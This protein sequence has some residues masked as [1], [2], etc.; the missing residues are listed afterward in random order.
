[1]N[2][3][4]VGRER[5]HALFDETPDGPVPDGLQAHF[6]TCAGC[7]ELHEEL[8]IL[9]AALRA[10][11]LPPM[12]DEAL[13]AVWERTVRAPRTRWLGAR[14]RAA[15]AAVLV[16]GVSVSTL[17]LLRTSPAPSGPT[18]AEIARA[19]A[20]ADLVLAYTARA[21][22]ATRTATTRSVVG[23]KISPAVRGDVPSDSRRH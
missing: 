20:Q 4:D 12:P 6:A 5:V 16:T 13:D 7:R 15:V 9:R 11:T 14:R 23:S 1:M 8:T 2:A 10:R 3:C 17:W 18:P 21:F 22:A 19:E